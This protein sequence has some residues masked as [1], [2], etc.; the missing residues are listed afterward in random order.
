MD[1]HELFASVV[2]DLPPLDDPT[3]AVLET[4]RRRR[5]RTRYALTASACALVIGA[6][7]I[8]V[9]APWRHNTDTFAGAGRSTSPDPGYT[10]L[11]PGNFQLDAAYGRYEA[12]MIQSYWPVAG[13][14]V[15]WKSSWVAVPQIFLNFKVGGENYQGWLGIIK[16]WK[17]ELEG[18][19]IDKCYPTPPPGY[20]KLGWSCA[21]AN[22]P[23]GM[24]AMIEHYPQDGK[25]GTETVQLHLF[26]GLDDLELIVDGHAAQGIT[27]TQFL[28]LAESPGYQQLFAAAQQHGFFEVG[29]L[30]GDL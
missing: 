28:A 14:S 1:L 23:N 30:V 16:W 22:L 11:P 2:D 6:G 9:A 18:R 17:Q 29:G 10:M 8:T 24:T 4:V 21:T 26:R 20:P 12:S 13:V 7:T 3:A 15:T 19:I 27:D 5:T 25:S